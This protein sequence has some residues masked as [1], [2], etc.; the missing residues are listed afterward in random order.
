MT[1]E[2]MKS[3]IEAGA[4]SAVALVAFGAAFGCTIAGSAA[5]GSWKKCYLQNKLAP[6]Q[7]VIFTGA[8]L[9]QV[10]YGM[11]LMFVL[12]GKVSPEVIAKTPA[13]LSMWPALLAIG[14]LSGLVMLVCAWIQGKAAAVCCDAMA[15]TGKGFTN[16]LIVL[17]IIETVSIFVM[18][19]A[20]ILVSQI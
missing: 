15:E 1:N 3:F 16:Y 10:I 19:F 18:A 20:M 7:L 14:M 4:F 9:T 5:V 6:F 13:V 8:P 17:G 12:A 2:L 11:I